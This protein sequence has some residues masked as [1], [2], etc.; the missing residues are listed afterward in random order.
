MAGAGFSVGSSGRED[1]EEKQ[2]AVK[3]LTLGPGTAAKPKVL[4]RDQMGM[5]L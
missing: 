5:I 1:G 3:S 2:R 4:I